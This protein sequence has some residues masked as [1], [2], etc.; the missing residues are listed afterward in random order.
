MRA[1]TLPAESARTAQLIEV[2]DCIL[3]WPDMCTL[4]IH[5]PPPNP[6]VAIS[7]PTVL[8]EQVPSCARTA[9]NMKHKGLWTSSA[10]AGT[11]Q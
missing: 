8:R 5:I 6:C 11:G 1:L 10:R 9:T 4:I 2:T 7:T 3:T